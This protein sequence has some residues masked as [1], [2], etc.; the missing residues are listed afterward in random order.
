MI[1]ELC[2]D[3]CNSRDRDGHSLNRIHQAWRDLQGHDVERDPLYILNPGPY[4]RPSTRDQKRLPMATSCNNIMAEQIKYT[5]IFPSF[6]SIFY[7]N[8][9]LK[10]N[11]YWLA[12]DINL[13][14]FPLGGSYTELLLP[15][16]LT[17]SQ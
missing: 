1:E 12:F 5:A 2:A 4:E 15:W 9:F 6:N 10:T 8:Y 13:M 14:V 3:L 17:V 16:S 11:G 7:H